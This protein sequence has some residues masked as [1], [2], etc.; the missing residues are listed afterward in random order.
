MAM[1][2]KGLGLANA[3]SP[4]ASPEKKKKR[5]WFIPEDSQFRRDM[6]QQHMTRDG[7]MGAYYHPQDK[8]SVPPE[9]KWAGSKW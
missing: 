1:T 9:R 5:V 2:Q 6:F 3:A 8:P 4:P 7:Y